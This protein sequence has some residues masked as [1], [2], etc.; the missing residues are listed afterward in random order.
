[1]LSCRK[2]EFARPAKVPGKKYQIRAHLAH[3]GHPIV[4]DKIYNHAGA[5]YLKIAAGSELTAEDL[6][7]LKSPTHL[8]HTHSM[9]LV[10]DSSSQTITSE[11][12]SQDW[13]T[14]EKS[15]STEIT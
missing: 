11:Y 13:L 6:S 14:F 8:L 1:M 2:L 15:V 4:G 3:L 5:F 7:I 10:L 9:D 12:F